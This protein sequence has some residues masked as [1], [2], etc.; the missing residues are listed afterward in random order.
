MIFQC[1]AVFVYTYWK[2]FQERRAEIALTL[3]RQLCHTL[4]LI[5]LTTPLYSHAAVIQPARIRL[6][7]SKV[8]VNSRKLFLLFANELWCRLVSTK[9]LWELIWM[10]Q[11]RLVRNQ[12]FHKLFQNSYETNFVGFVHHKLLD[13]SI[14]L[15]SQRCMLSYTVIQ[16][17]CHARFS[18]CTRIKFGSDRFA[19]RI[20]WTHSQALSSCIVI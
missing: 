17:K 13:I 12:L 11:R 6:N 8:K 1:S 4:D 5:L 10:N 19:W 14:L 2:R 20:I 9:P 16:R 3:T 7:R 18:A 15:F